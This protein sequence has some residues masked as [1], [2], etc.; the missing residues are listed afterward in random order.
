MYVLSTPIRRGLSIRLCVA[1]LVSMLMGQLP[2][3]AYAGNQPFSN[4]NFATKEGLKIH[5]RLW[6]P[7]EK[8]VRGN[9]LMVHGFAG[10]SFSW[11]QV[12]DSLLQLGYRTVA[13]DVPPFGFS[14]RAPRQNQSVGFRA[15]LLNTLLEEIGP[16]QRWHLSGHSMGGAIVQAMALLEP[17]RFVS[18][19]LVGAALF[20]TLSPGRRP[21]P[22]AFNLPGLTTFV[23][24]V[25]ESWV[26]TPGRIESFLASAYGQS[27]TADQTQ[28][29]VKTLSVPGTARAILN[30]PRFSREIQ[31]LYAG[32]L[33]VPAIAIWGEADAWVPLQSRKHIL[34]KMPTVQLVVMPG[35]GHNP[36]ETHFYEYMEIY[37]AFLNNL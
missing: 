36:M 37:L 6:E 8:E 12:A 4:S 10:S 31:S 32:N 18:V 30:G 26:L 25:A 35:V 29:Y 34:E 27:P 19:N 15:A 22:V 7:A 16:G 13:V 1:I 2:T 3:L 20:D 21:F 11:E 28:A 33:I 5:Y 9:M 23:G 17:G 24:S 14:D